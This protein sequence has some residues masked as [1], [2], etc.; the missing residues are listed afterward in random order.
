MILATV[1]R[2]DVIDKFLMAMDK[3]TIRDFEV[4]IVDQNEGYFIEP[5]I[6]KYKEKY[7]IKHIKTIE[8]GLSRARNI[9]MKYADGEIVCFPDDDC[10]YESNTIE[11]VLYAFKNKKLDGLICQVLTEND[12]QL[13]PRTMSDNERLDRSNVWNCAVSISIFLRKNVINTVGCFDEKIGVGANTMFGSGEETD[14]L[15]RALSNKFNIV[16]NKNVIIHHPRKEDIIDGSSINRVYKYGCGCGY[17][18]MKN[19][20]SLMIK[21]RFIIR[22]L[23]GTLLALLYLKKQLAAKRW[24]TFLGRIKGMK[25]YVDNSDKLEY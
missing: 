19:K 21:F 10:Y 11:A 23:M 2:Y 13:L 7:A 25:L 1:G 6:D 8:K 3:Q 24:Y 17:V 18:L 16:F 22:P 12:E 15:Y 14:Y 5:L 9:G 4:I 20:A